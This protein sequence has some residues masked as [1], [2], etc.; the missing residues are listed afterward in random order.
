MK[1][2]TVPDIIGID[3]VYLAVSDMTRSEQFYDRVMGVL[4][5]RRRERNDRWTD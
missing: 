4:G 2:R 5:F 3:H 1:V